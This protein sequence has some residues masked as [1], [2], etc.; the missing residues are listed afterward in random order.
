MLLLAAVTVVLDPIASPHITALVFPRIAC[1]AE[2]RV[3]T[4]SLRHV[5]GEVAATSP[6]GACDQ[7]VQLDDVP[8]GSRLVPHVDYLCHGSRRTETGAPVTVPPYVWNAAVDGSSV[9][10]FVHARPRASELLRVRVATGALE[11]SASFRSPPFVLRGLELTDG[12]LRVT[13]TLEP[14]GAVSNTRTL[15]LTRDDRERVVADSSGCGSSAALI[16]LVL[17]RRRRFPFSRRFC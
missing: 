13:A 4:V 17:F 7:T 16:P 5:T 15:R 6:G 2:C 10:A 14:Y 8:F 11:A 1:A 12:P 9:T 3:V